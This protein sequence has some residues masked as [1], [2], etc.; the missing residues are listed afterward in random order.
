MEDILVNWW[1]QIKEKDYFT[2]KMVKEELKYCNNSILCIQTSQ[3]NDLFKSMNST[4]MKVWKKEKAEY[5]NPDHGAID[6]YCNE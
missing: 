2:P 1:N 6:I 4:S 3:S 5:L